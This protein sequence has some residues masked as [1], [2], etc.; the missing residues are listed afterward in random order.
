MVKNPRLFLFRSVRNLGVS[1]IFL[2]K[3]TQISINFMPGLQNLCTKGIR[4]NVVCFNGEGEDSEA[5]HCKFFR[6]FSQGILQWFGL[7][8]PN[9]YINILCIF[10]YIRKDPCF[11]NGCSSTLRTPT[12]IGIKVSQ[13]KDPYEHNGMA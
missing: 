4:D 13:Y 9:M 2:K 11:S 8:N 5:A 1:A 6:Q 12:Y 7:G 3:K 10:V